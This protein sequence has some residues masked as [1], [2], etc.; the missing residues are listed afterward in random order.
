MVTILTPTYNREKDLPKLYFSLCKQT[1]TNF[2]WLVVDDGS[3]DNTESLINDFIS[4]RIISIKYIKKTNGGKHTA[5]NLGISQINSVLT[6]IVDSDDSLSEDAVDKI[7]KYH[8][9]YKNNNDICGYSFLRKDENGKINGKKIDMDEKIGTLI[10]VRINSGDD[11]SDKA[12]VYY[13]N[14]LHQ[15]TFPEFEGEKFLGEDVVW[16]RMARKYKMVFINEAI[17]IG[18]YLED[19]LTRNRRKNNIKS[20]KGCVLRA[21]EYMHKDINLKTREKSTLQYLI[22]GWFAKKTTIEL[23]SEIDLKL[24]VVFNIIPAR[25]MY[26]KWKKEYEEQK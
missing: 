15:F 4:D 16:M 20:P 12:E 23:I 6:F 2:E 19:G 8:N 9:K 14:C 17:Y 21:R 1:N 3:S 25:I 7:I 10:D 11:S 5:L 13:S 22:Y 26:R 18:T 24:I